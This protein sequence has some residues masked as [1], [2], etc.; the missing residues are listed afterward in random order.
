MYKFV[1]H[2]NDGETASNISAECYS[3][4]SEAI[5]A[6]EEWVWDEIQ[7]RD[8]DPAMDDPC[9]TYTIIDWQT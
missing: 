9:P 3:V 6:A 5:E 8:L 4:E 2:T 1:M 7:A